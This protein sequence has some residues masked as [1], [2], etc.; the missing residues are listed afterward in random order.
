[1]PDVPLGKQERTY[2]FRALKSALIKGDAL[3]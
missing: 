2:R 3:N 1:M